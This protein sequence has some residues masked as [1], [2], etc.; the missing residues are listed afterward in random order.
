MKLLFLQKRNDKNAGF[1]IFL[2]CL[3]GSAEAC[4]IRLEYVGGIDGKWQSVSEKQNE[5]GEVEQNINDACVDDFTNFI[6]QKGGEFLGILFN[7]VLQQENIDSFEQCMCIRGI[8]EH[9]IEH[10]HHGCLF[11]MEKWRKSNKGILDKA[12]RKYDNKNAQV[13][14]EINVKLPVKSVWNVDK[15]LFY[16]GFTVC[17]PYS[18]VCV[19]DCTYNADMQGRIIAFYRS[20]VTHQ[21]LQM[22]GVERR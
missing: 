9:N 6:T 11:G 7:M 20:I 13:N 19:S 5:N 10:S 8:V 12:Y 1:F 2:C 17:M 15:R 4:D 3:C 14:A 21:D 16:S 18:F 22:I